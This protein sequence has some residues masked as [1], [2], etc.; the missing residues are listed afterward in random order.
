MLLLHQLFVVVAELGVCA[1]RGMEAGGKPCRHVVGSQPAEGRGGE[2]PK[3]SMRPH[4]AAS[5]P[6][7]FLL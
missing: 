2:G 5:M 1:R 4:R 7:A 3:E 6:L